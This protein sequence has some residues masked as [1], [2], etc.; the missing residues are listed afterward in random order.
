MAAAVR[1]VGREAGNPGIEPSSPKFPMAATGTTP[2]ATKS[3]MAVLMPASTSQL[4]AVS[5]VRMRWV[6]RLSRVQA[7]AARKSPAQ[8]CQVSSKS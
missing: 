5:T 6:S 1:T 3:A 7:Q 2:A 8:A 4:T